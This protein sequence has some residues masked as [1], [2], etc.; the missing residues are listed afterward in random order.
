MSSD[1]RQD[2]IIYQ[3]QSHLALALLIHNSKGE[4]IDYADVVALAKRLAL[5]ARQPNLDALQAKLEAEKAKK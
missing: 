4:Q 2:S 5:N 1:P 3:N